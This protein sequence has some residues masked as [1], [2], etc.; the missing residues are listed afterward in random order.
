MLLFVTDVL[1]TATL[2]ESEL[3]MQRGW[4]AP[5]RRDTGHGT[6]D[7]GKGGGNICRGDDKTTL[8]ANEDCERT[9]GRRPTARSLHF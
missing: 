9:C 3:H 6:W 4:L 5:L 2:N 7:T 8:G 1:S